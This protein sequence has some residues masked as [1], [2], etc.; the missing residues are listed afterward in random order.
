[1]DAVQRGE[2]PALCSLQKCRRSP[3]ELVEGD[4]E[5]RAEDRGVGEE[6]ADG[7]QMKRERSLDIFLIPGQR[8]PGEG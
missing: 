6:A 4:L 5:H 2:E 7:E 3:A 1:M 8:V